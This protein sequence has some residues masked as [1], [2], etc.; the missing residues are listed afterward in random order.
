MASTLGSYQKNE[1]YVSPVARNRWVPDYN[2]WS[3]LII[4]LIMIVTD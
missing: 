3:F 2:Y 1:L 4:T